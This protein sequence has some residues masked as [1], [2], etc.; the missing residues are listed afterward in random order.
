MVKQL[1]K[2]GCIAFCSLFAMNCEGM[3]S[4]DT[5]AQGEQQL[6]GIAL[7]SLKDAYK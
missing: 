4:A 7:K 5:T 3:M 2:I 1:L 6:P